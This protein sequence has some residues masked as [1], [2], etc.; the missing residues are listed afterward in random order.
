MFSLESA[1][2]SIVEFLA[3]YWKTFFH[4]V[5]RPQKF[6]TS[7]LS[8]SNNYLRAPV[9]LFINGLFALIF[10]QIGSADSLS[11]TNIAAYSKAFNKYSQVSSFEIIKLAAPFCLIIYLSIACCVLILGIKKPWK[12]MTLQAVVTWFSSWLLLKCLAVVILLILS[13]FL[14][15]ANG[16]FNPEQKFLDHFGEILEQGGLTTLGIIFLLPYGAILNQ[17]FNFRKWLTVRLLLIT[18]FGFYLFLKSDNTFLFLDNLALIVGIKEHETPTAP[19]ILNI[20]PEKKEIDVTERYYKKDSIRLQI[21]LLIVN[22]TEKE[23]YIAKDGVLSLQPVPGKLDSL[24]IVS[25]DFT[26]K[27]W[28]KN[29]L[30]PVLFIA[31][32]TKQAISFESI[33]G[34]DSWAFLKNKTG[35]AE[36]QI[37]I[38]LKIFGDDSPG[39]KSFTFNKQ[40]TFK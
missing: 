4:S 15:P 34:K 6:L 39:E 40:L 21:D 7:L 1:F 29:D 25:V 26:I 10:H 14:D 18:F 23:I 33:T 36:K 12:K 28:Y 9:Y 38:P 19:G 24:K 37:N 22:D 35:N 31:P 5:L 8:G 17:F 3:K 16:Y 13:I 11:W 30:S 20:V 27:T 2:N 32:K